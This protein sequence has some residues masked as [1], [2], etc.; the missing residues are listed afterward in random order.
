M[1]RLAEKVIE[2][3]KALRTSGKIRATLTKVNGV[4]LKDDCIAISNNLRQKV[5]N[6]IHHDYLSSWNGAKEHGLQ[7]FDE[8]PTKKWRKRSF[9]SDM[10]ALTAWKYQR[11]TERPATVRLW[12]KLAHEKKQL[13]LLLETGNCYFM[14]WNHKHKEKWEWNVTK[15]IFI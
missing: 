11:D 14:V 9:L 4:S 15:S 13:L 10:P 3:E 2:T 1:S 8:H 6:W 12:N 7:H 5:L